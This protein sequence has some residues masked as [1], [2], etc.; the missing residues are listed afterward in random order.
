MAGF[1]LNDEQWAVI[2]QLLPR[3]GRGPALTFPRREHP[4]PGVR[5]V[6]RSSHLLSFGNA[7]HTVRR[8]RPG[9]HSPH[10]AQF[11][12]GPSEL[13]TDNEHPPMRRGAFRNTLIDKPSHCRPERIVVSPRGRG[14]DSRL[15]VP[16]KAAF[17]K[18]RQASTS[19]GFGAP[20]SPQLK[21]GSRKNPPALNG[22]GSHIS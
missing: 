3:K 9:A 21:A 12:N 5:S 6:V 20:S 17:P 8:R 11:R 18:R 19:P 14:C 1:D 13:R 7:S 10:T 22:M 16:S 2:E 15:R 4:L